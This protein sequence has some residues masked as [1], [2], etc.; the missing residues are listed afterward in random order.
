MEG[1]SPPPQMPAKGSLNYMNNPNRSVDG[2]IKSRKV[3]S[4]KY[5]SSNDDSQSQQSRG[6]PVSLTQVR[7][8][9]ELSKRFDIS[10]LQAEHMKLL[11]EIVIEK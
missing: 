1:T 11:E 3:V 7:N 6:R 10:A 5:L 4:R 9:R 2:K 8:Q